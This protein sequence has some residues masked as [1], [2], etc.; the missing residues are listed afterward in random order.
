MNNQKYRLSVST[1]VR[2]FLLLL[3]TTGAAFS[4]AQ[5]K[6][7][8]FLTSHAETG[9]SGT[10][11]KLMQEKLEEALQRP[12]EYKFA[13]GNLAGVGVEPDGNT[14]LMSV[15]GTMTLMPALIEDYELDPFTDLRPVTRVTITPDLFIARADLEADSIE[16]LVELAANAD[17]PLSYFHIAPQSIH[18]V[19]MESIFH[20]FGIDNVEL[21]TSYGR[22]PAAALE[23]IKAGTLDMMSLTS[24]HVVP[25]LE[26]G[27]AKVLAV[28]N[29]RRSPLAPD[30]P[31]LHELGI[32][33]MEYGSWAGIYVPAGTSDEDVERVFNAV[34]F[35]LEDPETVAKINGIGLEIGLSESPEEFV[36]FIKSETARFQ[37]AVDK[38]QITVE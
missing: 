17:K 28:F 16:E 22:G 3:L 33:T 18:R 11:A 27:E 8:T 32:T 19:E 13:Q 25:L 5:D 1:V 6:P 2:F 21:G 23:A 4:Q 12:L 37:T 24:P 35:T 20:E 10:T 26:N 15:S 9:S 38:Y 29:P 31:T 14:M 7:M 34:K 30:A 36:E